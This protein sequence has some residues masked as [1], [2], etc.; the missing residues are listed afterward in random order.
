MNI[1]KL[2]DNLK[3]EYKDDIIV[4]K[5]STILLG[6]EKIPKAK[7]MLF[8]GLTQDLINDYLVS[9]YSYSFPPEY[10]VF[11]KAFNGA[12][13]FTAKITKNGREFA[14]ASFSIYGLPRTQPFDRPA[15]MEEPYDLRIEDLARNKA[16]PDTWLKFGHYNRTETFGDRTDLF[17]DTSSG[18]VYCCKKNECDIL[19][20]WES[21]DSCLCSIFNVMSKRTL[22]YKY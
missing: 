18:K 20:E 10:I 16:L 2:I 19:E 17:I 9:N 14:S 15:D 11:L 1:L 13:L 4:R 7:H 3:E 8:E 22:N 21:L 6:I 5:N 12:N